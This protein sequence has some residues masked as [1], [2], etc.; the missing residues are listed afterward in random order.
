[1]IY[2]LLLHEHCRANRRNLGGG[3]K[4]SLNRDHMFN[5]VLSAAMCA[6][7][8]ATTGEY[9]RKLTHP[10]LQ[11]TVAE[12]REIVGVELVPVRWVEDEEVVVDKATDVEVLVDRA[13]D[14]AMSALWS[15]EH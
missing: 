5:Q 3:V 9:V 2:S 10:N 15:M 4:E 7:H 8:L 1:M 12:D 6:A 11:T 14:A 13:A